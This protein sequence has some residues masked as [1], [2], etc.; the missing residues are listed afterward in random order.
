MIPKVIHY[1]WF[2]GNELPP[3]AKHCIASWKKYCPDYKIIEWN[4]SN[5]DCSKIIYM[6]EAY[7]AKKWAFVS[8]YARLD[9]I[10]QNGGVYL[11]IDVEVIQNLDSLLA[12]E[13]FLGIE[14]TNMIATGLGFGAEAKNKNIKMMLEQYDNIHFKLGKDLYD[15]LPCPHRNT[16][17]F[18]KLGFLPSNKPQA[19]NGAIIYPAEYFSPLN[20]ETKQLIITDNTMTIHHYNASWI[21][22]EEKI[23][24]IKV[25]EYRKHHG[26]I[27][28]KIY[29]N[30]CEY[31][32]EYDAIKLNNIIDF[33]CKKIKRRRNRLSQDL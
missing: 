30:Y 16:L 8:D 1:C 4:E 14:T 31:Q 22:K 20:Y 24:E 21:T 17:P 26:K 13:C 12:C 23:L 28:S 18:Q 15:T 6:K 11:D 2:G 32:M 5:Y 10:Y 25:K 3:I 19:I 7:E 29:K 33:L 9:I 27:R